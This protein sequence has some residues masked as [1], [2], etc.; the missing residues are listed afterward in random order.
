MVNVGAYGKRL[1]YLI[2]SLAV[3][4]GWVSLP[5]DATSSAIVSTPAAQ[6]SSLIPTDQSGL[7]A[8][9]S[10]V[11]PPFGSVLIKADRT[12][13][14]RVG[15]L[16]DKLPLNFE[17]NYGQTDSQVKFFSHG[18]GYSL[19]LTSS[20][21]VLVL[22]KTKEK[23]EGESR[24]PF[25]R[26]YQPLPACTD[27]VRMKLLGAN[28]DPKIEGIDELPGKSNYL[29]GNDPAKWRI[30]IPSYARVRYQDVYPG[31]DL[32][33]YGNQRQLEYDLIIAA[34]VDPGL[35]ELGFE[36]V[37]KIRINKSGDL[38]LHTASGEIYQ[39][40]PMIYQQSGAI[41]QAVVG[42]YVI[43]GKRKIGFQ[44]AGYDVS[45][46]LV[47]DPVL[48]Y[49]TYLGSS[50]A[51][52]GGGIAVDSAGNVYVTGAASTNFPTTAGA[53][54]P[55]Y[56]GATD[57]FVAKLDA[58]GA[59]LIYSTYLGGGGIDSG[60][61]IVVD[62]SGNVLLA[63]PTQSPDFPTTAGAFQATF[64]GRTDAFVAKLNATGTAFIYST[65]LGGSG[66]DASF[67]IAADSVGNAY[68]TGVASINFPTTPGA[69]QTTYG[70]AA[71]VFVTKLNATGTALIYSTYLG[72]SSPDF[73][74][75]IALDSAGNAYV[76]GQTSSSNFP[77]TPGAFQMTYGG[78][79]S[80]AFVTKLNPGGTALV[81]STFLGGSAGDIGRSIA[82]DSAG[83]TYVTG[84]ASAGFPT[85]PDALQ[86]AF[87]GSTDAFVAKIN[88][89]GTV[90]IYST[91]IGG[92]NNDE[93]VEV[94][95]DASGNVYIT[96][97]TR[98]LDF[99]TTP[100][101]LQSNTVG[102]IFIVKISD[103]AVIAP[104]ITR[105]SIIGKNLLVF[106][107][108]F[109]SGA[110]IL[111]NGE[112]QKTIRDDQNPTTTLIG[113]RLGKKIAPGE[114]VKLQVRNSDGALSNEFSFTRPLTSGVRL[115]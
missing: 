105:V 83:N 76:T 82:V 9:A 95:A 24:D 38:V 2:L 21:A 60:S 101:A 22:S 40:K 78:G 7:T 17:A 1:A 79:P 114:T 66:D 18:N 96:G 57:A 37:E 11:Q 54:Q 15:D 6:A 71:D 86:T 32:I 89:A 47:I 43:R 46:P 113:K 26:F 90:L 72:G 88:A 85:T 23:G 14:A 70:G 49:S 31:V 42:S 36:G 92:S 52:S 93:G 53:L 62:S 48:A 108:N 77:T 34:G 110:V 98:S 28:P 112:Q 41:K 103:L 111:L 55:T 27:V 68:V 3:L 100:G 64:G 8:A 115:K 80:D 5:G 19:F 75:R 13:Q 29:I 59:A 51:D 87:G 39:R 30:N 109:D 91:L 16:Y 61:G 58:T 106:G 35:I 12:V 56:G 97:H 10:A 67:G 104:K 94:V 25:H 73:G 69:F 33:Y 84:A 74:R 107:E 44:I 99:P 20:E 102:G 65:Y 45:K 4:T 50:S 63:G 81:Y